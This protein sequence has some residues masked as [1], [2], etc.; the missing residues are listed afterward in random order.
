MEN[1]FMVHHRN[2]DKTDE[3]VE[4]L[5]PMHRGCHASHHLIGNTRTKGMKLG[6]YSEERRRAISE[7]CRGIPKRK[8]A[9]V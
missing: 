4:N 8:K 1:E 5:G 6:P 7:A 9:T 2:H 3:A